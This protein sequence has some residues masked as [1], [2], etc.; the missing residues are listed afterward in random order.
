VSWASSLGGAIQNHP[1]IS[2]PFHNAEEIVV[3][4]T[5]EAKAGRDKDKFIDKATGLEMENADEPELAVEWFST[6]YKEFGG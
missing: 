3:F 1:L 5:P 6:T 2:L 4:S